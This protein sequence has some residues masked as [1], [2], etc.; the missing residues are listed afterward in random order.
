MQAKPLT[1]CVASSTSRSEP[2]PNSGY[3]PEGVCPACGTRLLLE[4]RKRG[5]IWQFC[6]PQHDAGEGQA[7]LNELPEGFS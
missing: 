2:L 1:R 5:R 7:R 4:S 6:L 3:P